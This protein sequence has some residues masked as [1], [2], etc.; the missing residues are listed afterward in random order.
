MTKSD[1]NIMLK[2]KILYLYFKILTRVRTNRYKTAI[3]K[4]RQTQRELKRHTI[5]RLNCVELTIKT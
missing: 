1:P 2:S 5:I 4:S 3:L